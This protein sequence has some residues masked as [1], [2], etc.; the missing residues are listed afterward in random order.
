MLLREVFLRH[1][2][3]LLKLHNNIQD[4]IWNIF[5]THDLNDEGKG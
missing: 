2:E 1:S 5:R 3:K 4:D